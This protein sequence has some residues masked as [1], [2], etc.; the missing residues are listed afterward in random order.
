MTTK[1][2]IDDTSVL[3]ECLQKDVKKNVMHHVV[4]MTKVKWSDVFKLRP[5]TPL[6]RETVLPYLQKAPVDERLQFFSSFYNEMAKNKDF[7]NQ[8]VLDVK[9]KKPSALK[10][11]TIV[12]LTRLWETGTSLSPDY[13]SLM[14]DHSRDNKNNFLSLV[15]KIPKDKQETLDGRLKKL[16]VSGALLGIHLEATLKKVFYN[17]LYKDQVTTTDL[18]LA[19]NLPIVR[20]ALHDTLDFDEYEPGHFFRS[21]DKLTKTFGAGNIK[22]IGFPP[23]LVAKALTADIDTLYDG[24]RLS[25]KTFKQT[26]DQ[27]L[28]DLY[29][30]VAPKD[31]GVLLTALLINFLWQGY[32][33]P[34]LDR[35]LLDGVAPSGIKKIELGYLS[36]EQDPEFAL[37]GRTPQNLDEYASRSF[38]DFLTTSKYNK[39]VQKIDSDFLSKNKKSVHPSLQTLLNALLASMDKAPIFKTTDCPSIDFSIDDDT[40]AMSNYERN[41]HRAQ[42]TFCVTLNT[43]RKRSLI[44][45]AVKPLIEKKA[46]EEEDTLGSVK[47]VTRQL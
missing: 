29:D 4:D 32:T 15:K 24:S 31:R 39:L 44:Q 23:L 46:G 25:C 21:I 3:I 28:S 13:F 20:K 18:S 7:I 43:L 45:Q 42:A 30:F 41:F 26:S 12:G 33:N 40:N 19:D 35:L 1:T 6:W 9:D 10:T 34:L 2:P 38:F 37:E 5:E 22:T 11:K 14:A 36:V 17:L 16:G 27:K 47:K 8:I